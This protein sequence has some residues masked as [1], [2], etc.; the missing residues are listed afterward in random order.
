MRIDNKHA[1]A[2]HYQC[3][4]HEMSLRHSALKEVFS[5]QDNSAEKHVSNAFNIS[6]RL[7]ILQND[8]K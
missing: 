8:L 1:Y 7:S 5:N 6:I 2:L 3:Q 4:A